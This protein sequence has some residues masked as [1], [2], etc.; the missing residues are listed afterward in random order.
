MSMVH[1]LHAG[2]EYAKHTHILI[3]SVQDADNLIPDQLRWL[4]KR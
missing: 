2:T 1:M 3:I 4:V